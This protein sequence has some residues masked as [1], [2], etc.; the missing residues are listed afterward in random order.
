M[1][2]LKI[3]D[4]CLLGVSNGGRIALDFVTAHP[5]RVCGLVLVA[6][7][8]SG[9]RKIRSGGGQGLGGIRERRGL[10]ESGNQ[11]EQVARRRQDGP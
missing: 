11:G 4:A 9:Y 10:A 5:S 1:E 3:D 2:H 6:P 7:G 8:V